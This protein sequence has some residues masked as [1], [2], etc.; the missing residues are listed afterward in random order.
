MA[1]IDQHLVRPPKLS[2]PKTVENPYYIA[3]ISY[4]EGFEMAVQHI[5]RPRFD[6]LVDDLK[7]LMERRENSELM[8]A[9]KVDIN[10]DETDIKQ[11]VLKELE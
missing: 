9:A 11:K 4:D 7:H 3:E 1:E 10:G 2:K 5:Q 8:W 6:L